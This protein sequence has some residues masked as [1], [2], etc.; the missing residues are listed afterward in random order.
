MFRKLSSA[1]QSKFKYAHDPSYRPRGQDGLV[2]KALVQGT[3]DS[4]CQG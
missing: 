3:R 1:Y 4:L 2:D